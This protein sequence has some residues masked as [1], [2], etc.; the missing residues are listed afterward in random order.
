MN[1]FLKKCKVPRV[2][3]LFV[4]NIFITNCLE[5]ATVFN[6]Y[7][8]EQCTPFATVLPR[9]TKKTNNRINSFHVT[10]QEIKD[11]I[12]VLQPKKQMVLTQ[13]QLP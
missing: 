2:P 11:I 5:K 1:R 4:S 13:Y 8:A 3:P 6:S 12:S 9:M 10:L 7:F